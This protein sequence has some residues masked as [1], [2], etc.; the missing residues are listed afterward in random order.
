MSDLH[1]IDVDQ[2][3]F[4]CGLWFIKEVNPGLAKPPLNF[5]AV[6]LIWVNFLS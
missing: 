2:M 4:A 3:A 5:K 1:V 6:Q